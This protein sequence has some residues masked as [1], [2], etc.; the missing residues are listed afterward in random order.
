MWKR[1]MY[2]VGGRGNTS[3]KGRGLRKNKGGGENEVKAMQM[4]GGKEG[5]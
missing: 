2:Q 4:E 3:E 5:K 1:R